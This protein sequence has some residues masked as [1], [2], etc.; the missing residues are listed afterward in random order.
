MT[1]RKTTTPASVTGN[2]LT[3]LITASLKAVMGG[4]GGIPAAQRA[5]AGARAEIEPETNPDVSGLFY[6][7]VIVA[8]PK[9]VPVAG[10]EPAAKGL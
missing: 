7:S 4:R 2:Q 10:I 9:V 6:L 1:I 3:A 8:Y 5:K